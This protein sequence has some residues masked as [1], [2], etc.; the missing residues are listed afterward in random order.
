MV[1]VNTSAIIKKLKY[2]VSTYDSRN[3]WWEYAIKRYDIFMGYVR[4][5][6]LKHSNYNYQSLLKNIDFIKE[7]RKLLEAFGM[8]RRGSVLMKLEVFLDTISQTSQDFNLLAQA[9]IRL[10]NLNLKHKI[11]EENVSS[12]IS[13][14]YDLFSH[15]NRLSL[16]GGI[17]IASKTMHMIMPELFIMID[18]RI[19]KKLHKISDYHPHPNDGKSWYDVIPR[20]SG[21]KMNP[22]PG[23]AWDFDQCYLAAL[24]YYKRIILEWCQWNNTNI[25][26]FLE[27]GLRTVTTDKSITIKVRSTTARIIDMALW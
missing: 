12:I 9:N 10:E 24:M 3:S 25:E 13:R 17:V 22:Y 4:P 6:Y 19:M 20:Y 18:G 27:I 5:H 23:Y 11:G 16:S 2:L 15:L 26:S 7:L 14:I 8:N 1:G 21:Y